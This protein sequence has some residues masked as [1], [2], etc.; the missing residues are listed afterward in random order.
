L[1]ISTDPKKLFP[2]ECG[3]TMKRIIRTGASFKGFKTFAGDWFKK[4]YGYDFGEKAT[5][6][7]E[8]QKDIR[9]AEE[10]HKRDMEC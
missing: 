4:T 6:R 8:F 1:S 3:Y 2:C 5:T 9:R 7:A 10:K